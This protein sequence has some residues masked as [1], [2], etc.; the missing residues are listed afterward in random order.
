[1]D[2][3][4]QCSPVVP[5]NRASTSGFRRTSSTSVE[6]SYLQISMWMRYCCKK[7]HHQ[8]QHHYMYKLT[9]CRAVNTLQSS[10]QS[11]W[12]TLVLLVYLCRICISTLQD[13]VT[14]V[15][16]EDSKLVQ[17][18]PRRACPQTDGSKRRTLLSW[19]TWQLSQIG[20]SC[21]SNAAAA[22]P[23]LPKGK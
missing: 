2:A 16:P 21:N 1:M 10:M 23:S 17:G 20:M 22:L 15:S 12:D 13:D 19:L 4:L 11:F 3:F 7:I 14:D 6:P 9:L 5:S 18:W 8:H